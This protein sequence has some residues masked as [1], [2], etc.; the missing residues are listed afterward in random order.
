MSVVG[1]V[2]GGLCRG[3]PALADDSPGPGL[4]G[5]SHEV[6][7][8]C[9]RGGTALDGCLLVQGSGMLFFA[10]P[11]PAPSPDAGDARTADT[12]RLHSLTT[13]AFD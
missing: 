12:T 9:R 8:P 5:G 1:T 6:D 4:R 10:L 11:P 13:F 7:D 3:T 2:G